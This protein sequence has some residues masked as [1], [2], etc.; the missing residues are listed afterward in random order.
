MTFVNV[1]MPQL[2]R[3]P[4]AL[5]GDPRALALVAGMIRS[6]GGKPFHLKPESKSAYHLFGFFS[7]PAIVALLSAAESAA[8]LAGLPSVRARKLMAPIVHQT[9]HNCLTSNPR[10][11]FSGPLRRGDIATIRKHFLVLQ[12]DPQLR[13]LYRALVNI[14]MDRLPVK[15]ADIMKEIMLDEA[16]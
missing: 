5:E 13:A 2:D 1:A 15:D 4:F 9:I 8:G 3:V 6:I 14:A 16:P 11:A 12:R 10:E 7:S